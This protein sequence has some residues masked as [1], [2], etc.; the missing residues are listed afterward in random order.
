MVEWIDRAL[1][2]LLRFNPAVAWHELRLRMRGK[3]FLALLAWVVFTSL[4]V[5]VPVWLEALTRTASGSPE[6]MGRLGRTGMHALVY[7]EITLILLGIP[8]YAAA[9]IAAE[10]ERQTLEMLRATLL[11]PWDVVSGKL[12]PVLALAAILLGTTLPVAAWCVLLGGVSPGEV[13]Q[14]YLLMFA[15]AAVVAALGTFMSALFNRSLGAIVATY[16]TLVGGSV[17]TGFVAVMVAELMVSGTLS[18]GSPKIGVGAATVLVGAPVVATAALLVGAAWGILRRLP[19]G[20]RLPSPG[21]LGAMAG[22]VLFGILM[23]R[24]VPLVEA[25]ANAAPTALL[26]ATPYGAAAATLE[27]EVARDVFDPYGG[28]SPPPTTTAPTVAPQQRVWTA[29][30]WLYVVATAAL[31]ALAAWAYAARNRT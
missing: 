23:A 11:T 5:A 20:G 3:V 29:V 12:L 14:L 6:V 25:L 18:S 10:R 28:S 31:W 7:T 17:L 9:A 2:A 27:A 1:F 21:L 8:A 19:I 22:I 26:L 13:A 16:L 15:T 30:V 4:A 24:A